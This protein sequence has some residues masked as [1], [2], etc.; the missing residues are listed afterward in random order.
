M[1]RVND[2]NVQIR[3]SLKFCFSLEFKS[4]SAIFPLGRDVL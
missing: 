1:E 3:F 2:G 4:K